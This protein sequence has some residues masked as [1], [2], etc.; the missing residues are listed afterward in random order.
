MLDTVQALLGV[1]HV[2]KNRSE[3]V[4]FLAEVVLD[5]RGV[6]LEDRVVAR[7]DR[8]DVLEGHLHALDV[9]VEVRLELSG[10]FLAGHYAVEERHQV[11]D[12][13]FPANSECENNA[14]I[15]QKVSY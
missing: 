11:D 13:L 7:E 4:V 12:S 14:N 3:V 2:L 1:L 9:A 8:L 6:V 15:W 5:G 10:D